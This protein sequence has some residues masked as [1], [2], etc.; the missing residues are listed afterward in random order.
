[1]TVDEFKGSLTDAT[2]PRGLPPLLLALWHEGKGAWDAA[3]RV[4]Q[5]IDDADGARVSRP[6]LAP[7]RNRP[8]GRQ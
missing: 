8:C 7:Y 6:S 4:A 5:H 2:P 3:H 1:M